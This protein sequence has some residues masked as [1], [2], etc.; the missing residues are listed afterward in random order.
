MQAESAPQY[1]LT[2][3]QQQQ[4]ASDI[5]AAT[6][7]GVKQDGDQIRDQIATAAGDA[8]NAG[9]A[10]LTDNRESTLPEVVVSAPPILPGADT[11][12]DIYANLVMRSPTTG[13]PTYAQPPA[14]DLLGNMASLHYDLRQAGLVPAAEENQTIAE[15]AALASGSAAYGSLAF[16]ELQHESASD[17]AAIEAQSYGSVTGLWNQE[18]S[19]FKG[20]VLD[21]LAYEGNQDL[22]NGNTLGFVGT[23]LKSTFFETFMPGSVGQ[24]ALMLGGGEVVGPA[25]GEFSRFASDAVPLL[26]RDVTDLAGAA[27]NRLSNINPFTGSAAR[28][29]TTPLS[30]Q[31]GHL[32]LSGLIPGGAPAITPAGASGAS[33]YGV[34]FFGSSN[35]GYYTRAGA[36]LGTTG[37]S[38]FL[39]PLEDSSVVTDAASAARYTGMSPSTLDAY[40]NGGDIYGIS[41]PT[42]GYALS[43]PTA[44]DAAGWPHFL[45]GGNTAVLTGTGPNAGYLVNPTRE[46][47]T[48]GGSAVPSGSVLFQVGSNGEWIPVKR[49]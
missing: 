28:I 45:E 40:M 2:Q 22:E 31:L 35:L 47:V 23:G 33:D 39:M 21:E 26:G 11:A 3:A 49:F 41:F 43:T 36:T 46:F 14:V 19:A 27:W 9:D 29:G 44:A 25:V 42:K 4:E 34:A 6:S 32:D 38:F 18:M 5:S 48:P 15:Q 7:A 12:L 30:A 10:P 13:K 17:E 37:K 20:T 1:G 24:T 8:T 16:T